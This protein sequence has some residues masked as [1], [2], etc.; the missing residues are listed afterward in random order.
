[1]SWAG[2][3]NSC[4]RMPGSQREAQGR[5]GL[6]PKTFL[7]QFKGH[8]Y[9]TNPT[10]RVRYIYNP[11]EHVRFQS[12]VGDFQA[13]TQ[14]GRPEAE[15][16][17]QQKEVLEQHRA[18]VNRLCRHNYQGERRRVEPTVT[19]SPS[20]TEALNHH[21][22]LVCTVTDFCP[23]QIKVQWFQNDQEE[24]AGVVS[25][26]LIRNG[27]WT[28]QILVMLEMTSH[29]QSP[30][31]VEITLHT[32]ALEPSSDSSEGSNNMAGDWDPGV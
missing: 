24:T 32:V 4:L 5:M 27:H 6:E 12:D 8:C 28:F 18:E 22:L 30:I 31:T 17:N 3:R 15:A 29:L 7:F 20:R 11:E 10:Q 16:W 19:I 2:L 1:Q 14:L 26:P 21:N 25:T 23:G 9:F 13:V